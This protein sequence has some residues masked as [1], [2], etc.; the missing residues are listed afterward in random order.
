VWRDQVG[1]EPETFLDYSPNWGD[2][3]SDEVLTQALERN[4]VPSSVDEKQPGCVIAF[5][6]QERSIVKHVGITVGCDGGIPLMIH[7]YNN[8]GVVLAPLNAAW[9]RRCAGQ[10]NFPR[11]IV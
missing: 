8:R 9:L 7:S 2:A 1:A 10:Y 3:C 5:R 4:F 11:R 6:M